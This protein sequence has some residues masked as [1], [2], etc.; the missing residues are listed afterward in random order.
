MSRLAAS[1]C[2]FSAVTLLLV[3]GMACG[4]P[5]LPEVSNAARALA[6]ECESVTERRYFP[7]RPFSARCSPV[8]VSIAGLDTQAHP[9]FLE[10]MREPPL[11]CGVQSDS[12]RILW[13]HSFNEW[14]PN[15]ISKWPPTMA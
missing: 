13:I 4:S 8:G 11:S 10:A 9:G 12:Y 5:E 7:G 3:A 15:A 14:P 6:P 1:I 2:R